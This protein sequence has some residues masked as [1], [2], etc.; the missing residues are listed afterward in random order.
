MPTR[1]PAALLMA[2]LV[3]GCNSTEQ[4]ATTAHTDEHNGLVLFSY[5]DHSQLAV[6]T[7]AD[8]HRQLLDVPAAGPGASLLA[9]GDG[10]SAAVLAGGI[11]QF[12]D[13]GLAEADE[14]H[15]DD[16]DDEH[17]EQYEPPAIIALQSAADQVI[18]GNGFFSVLDGGSSQLLE[19]HELHDANAY[20]R[21]L[22]PAGL[23]QDH[24]AAVLDA[25]H[26]LYLVF[27]DKRA[28]VY[29]DDGISGLL[30]TGDSFACSRP[31]QLQQSASL[32]LVHCDE[33]WH[34]LLSDS[35][36]D[37]LQPDYGTLALAGLP[38]IEQWR[39]GHDMAIG[40][41]S[42]DL[43]LVML[44]MDH[45]EAETTLF[46]L[47]QQDMPFV[48]SGSRWCNAGFDANQRLLLASDTGRLLVVDHNGDVLQQIQLDESLTTSLSCDDLLIRNSND[49][50]AILDK[51]SARLYLIDAHNG[52]YAIHR[53]LSV[54]HAATIADMALLLASH[55]DHDEQHDGELDHEH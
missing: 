42:N 32:L 14:D 37:P 19:W 29:H 35:H 39:I 43:S 51:A 50:V 30:A 9:A 48:P 10:L 45:D 20:S 17:A 18:A 6:I 13:S 46:S 25:E 15:D 41:N 5:T 55:D 3:G 52:P 28:T 38:A 40:F 26:G 22:A 49:S 1:I 8:G 33:G 54:D 47:Q 44:H 7:L 16:H 24:A 53:R 27:A 34:W 23:L 31:A 12:V 36:D 11:V 2:V 4:S 21:Q